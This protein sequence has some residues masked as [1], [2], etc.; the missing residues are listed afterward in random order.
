MKAPQ[1]ILVQCWYDKIDAVWLM[2]MH[3]QRE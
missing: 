2:R 1:E 3:L